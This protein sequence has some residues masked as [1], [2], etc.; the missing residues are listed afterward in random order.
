M[1]ASRISSLKGAVCGQ[2]GLKRVVIVGGGYCGAYVASRMDRLASMHVTLI[3]TKE[4]F[5]QTP[6]MPRL[7]CVEDEE[8]FD[9]CHIKHTEYVRRGQVEIGVVAAVRRDHVLVGTVGGVAS[10]A[11]P[12]DFLV[13]A[14]GTS[15]ES[16]C[17]PN[18]GMM[19]CATQVASSAREAV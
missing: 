15:C 18:L 1:Q 16:P 14:T 12:F 2:D 11:I 10:R 7:L 13:I 5:E 6:A 9:R 19:H 3:D 8:L 4:Y 17:Q